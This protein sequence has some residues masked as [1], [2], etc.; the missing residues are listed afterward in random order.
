MNMISSLSAKILPENRVRAILE[1]GKDFQ[2]SNLTLILF[3]AQENELSRVMILD[4]VDHHL[5]FT[6]HVRGHAP[7]R[8]VKLSCL[9]Y[10]EE[11]LQDSLTI[12]LDSPV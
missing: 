12:D 2:K 3:D 1:L 5:E 4:Q 11:N 7:A 8:P 9:V 6:L 10:Q